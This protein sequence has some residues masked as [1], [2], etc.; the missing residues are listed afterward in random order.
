VVTTRTCSNGHVVAEDYLKVCPKCGSQLAHAETDE[1]P[2]S[3]APTPDEPVRV[4]RTV[5]FVVGG[6]VLGLWGRLLVHAAER[7]PA[8]DFGYVLMAAG[9]VVIVLGFADAVQRRRNLP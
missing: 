7:G 2:P 4:P 5:P 9:L 8:E 3:L 6:I 1:K